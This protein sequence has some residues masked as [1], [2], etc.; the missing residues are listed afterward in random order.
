MERWRKSTH[1]LGD[2]DFGSEVSGTDRP[3]ILQ[4]FRTDRPNPPQKCRV[5][6]RFLHD[7]DT[8]FSRFWHEFHRI[9]TEIWV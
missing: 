8:N 9:L 7:S 2:P 4:D 6:A 1:D 3:M 5:L